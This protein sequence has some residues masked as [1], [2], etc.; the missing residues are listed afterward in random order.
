[1]TGDEEKLLHR[2]LDGAI[3]SE[4]FALLEELLRTDPE[5]RRSLRTLA[6]IDSKWQQLAADEDF[7]TGPVEPDIPSIKRFWPMAAGIVALVVLGLFLFVD[8]N[9][10]ESKMI[11]ARVIHVEGE[12]RVNGERQ[13]AI[14]DELFAGDEL[15]MDTGL[16]E[17][18]YRDSGVHALATAPLALDLES[19]MH[20]NLS[21]GEM[22]LVVPPQ[23]IGF[24]V[25][26]PERKI[27]DLGT[28]FVVKANESGS[29][30]LVLDGQIA[31]NGEDGNDEQRM[32]AGDLAKFSRDGKTQLHSDMPPNIA[33]LTAIS[34]SPESRSLRG[35]ILGF[36]G[37]PVIPR[38]KR[39]QDVIAR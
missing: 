12:G 31:I 2:Y 9:P 4:E 24:V 1:M 8:W 6:T 25:D 34:L 16:V 27:T 11:V 22:K 33:E 26:T 37:S 10:R 15:T 5:A 30:V 3:S 39:N 18:A 7:L 36:E 35:R 32:F 21:K 28:S 19:T 38:Q 17:L 13:L 20:V 23:G 29:R 14:G